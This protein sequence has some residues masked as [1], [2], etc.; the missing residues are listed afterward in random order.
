MA[1]TGAAPVTLANATN[2]RGGSWTED[3]TIV[4]APGSTTGLWRVS[5]AGGT[6]EPLTT[7]APGESTHRWPQV[8]PDGRILYTVSAVVTNYANAWLAVK[9]LATGEPAVVL[10][11]GFYGRYL[12]GG[13]GSPTRTERDDGHL[14]WVHDGTLFAASFELA[15][16][17]VTGPSMPVVPE[18]AS[19]AHNGSAQVDVF[20]TGTLVY[21]PSGG[22]M[23]TAP[24][25][26]L[27][28]DGKARPLEV[29]PADWS[30]LQIASDGRR[31][32][33]S[34]ADASNQDVW[35]YDLANG[36]LTPLTFD[37]S[38]DRTPVWTPD[39]HRLVYASSR[40]G[41]VVNLWWQRADGSGEA[42]RLTTG[43]NAQYPGSWHPNGRMLAFQENRPQTGTDLLIPSV[44]GDE[45]SGWRPGTA[46]VLL[47]GPAAEQQPRFSPDGQ[48]LAYESDES[49]TGFEIYV[50][51]FPG[52]GGKVRVSTN[53]GTNAVWS[54][55]RP[56]NELLYLG[57]RRSDHDGKGTRPQAA[58]FSMIGR[59]SGARLRSSSDRPLGPASISTRA[60][61]AW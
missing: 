31:L 22:N 48:W 2:A 61:H 27:T 12:S 60:A 23:S 41:S 58:C 4:F 32:A 28:R 25:V 29:T 5:A 34:I 46:A 20:G 17:T 36:T 52:P 53:G 45:V 42:M 56:L 8:L 3:G 39:G 57:A 49:Q 16:L 55:A 54:R 15:T 43:P 59:S 44:E 6:A 30:G 1:V 24:L 37:P 14:A 21:L 38:A 33:F 19:S 10:R 26:W 9:A 51:P 7:L 13:R 18:V 50:Q 35:T 40:G 47:S 11:G